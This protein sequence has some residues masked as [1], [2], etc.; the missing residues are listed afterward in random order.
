MKT[1]K[2][3]V[4]ILCMVFLCP[5]CGYDKDALSEEEKRYVDSLYNQSVNDFRRTIDSICNKQ[6]DALFNQVIDSL[7]KERLEEIEMLTQKNHLQ[8]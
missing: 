3:A 1:D 4:F 8:Q 2:L 6:K 7:K 5:S